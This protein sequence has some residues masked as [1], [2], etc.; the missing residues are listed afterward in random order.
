MSADAKMN[1]ALLVA[2]AAAIGGYVAEVKQ[3][4]VAANVAFVVAVG[5]LVAGAWWLVKAV[6]EVSS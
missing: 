3:W 2:F 4:A 6:R 1:A 5:A